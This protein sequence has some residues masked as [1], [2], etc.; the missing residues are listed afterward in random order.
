SITSSSQ[1]APVYSY[2][3]S[4]NFALDLGGIVELYPSSR[5]TLRIEVGDTHLYF[6][7]RDV[8]VNG[9]L[10]SFPG[11]KLRHTI[12]LVLGYGWRF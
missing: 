7:T 12:Q 2:A 10:Q 11:G 9:T 4:T 3:R 5:S 1:S 8:N 6:V